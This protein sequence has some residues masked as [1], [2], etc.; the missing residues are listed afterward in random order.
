MTDLSPIVGT[1]PTSAEMGETQGYGRY[2]KIRK[3]W[4][5]NIVGVIV[6]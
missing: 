6:K 4:I 1:W 2:E 3:Y 5:K